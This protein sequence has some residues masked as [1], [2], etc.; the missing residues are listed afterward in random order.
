MFILVFPTFSVSAGACVYACMYVRLRCLYALKL[1]S[2]G[3]Q[4][5]LHISWSGY[6]GFSILSSALQINIYLVPSCVS[7]QRALWRSHVICVARLPV[8]PRCC[9][10]W[11]L[12]VGSKTAVAYY[13]YIEN[14]QFPFVV[15][16]LEKLLFCFAHCCDVVCHV[17]NR[18]TMFMYPLW[19]G[20]RRDNCT[21]RGS[22]CTDSLHRVGE[23][24]R[25]VQKFKLS[26][27]S[28][29]RRGEALLQG[30]EALNTS[31]VRRGNEKDLFIERKFFFKDVRYG[32]GLS[33]KGF[34]DFCLRQMSSSNSVLQRLH[35]NYNLIGFDFVTLH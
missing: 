22:F 34:R 21:G 2:R 8:D 7:F 18:V 9:R 6:S 27:E 11:S 28:S 35:S 29:A 26:N 16:K 33:L 1:R 10:K 32:N 15:V 4:S 20:E 24:E 31:S 23:G 3:L 5:A 13:T 12:R 19:G 25:R 30:E 14:E 17:V